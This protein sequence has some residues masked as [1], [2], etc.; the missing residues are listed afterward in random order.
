VFRGVALVAIFPT[1]GEAEKYVMPKSY[2]EFERRQIDAAT[3]GL[4]MTYTIQ[5][6]AVKIMEEK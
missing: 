6:V 1:Q 5:P 4:C 3:L 2:Q